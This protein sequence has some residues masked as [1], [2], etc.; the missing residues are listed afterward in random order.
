MTK[1]FDKKVQ[2]KLVLWDA[3]LHLCK[4]STC[5]SARYK[6]KDRKKERKKERE[7]K[8]KERKSVTKRERERQKKENNKRK[9]YILL[10]CI[11]TRFWVLRAPKSWLNYFFSA[12]FNK[13]STKKR[14]FRGTPLGSW[15]A[16]AC[17]PALRSR[18]K[19]VAT[20]YSKAPKSCAIV[21]N[22]A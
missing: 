8:K 21:L 22:H 4:T 20:N 17:R 2:S 10:L 11:L 9:K 18:Q 12:V 3:L 14:Q 7:Q 6:K 19:H 5:V 15:P 13:K 1:A 16:C